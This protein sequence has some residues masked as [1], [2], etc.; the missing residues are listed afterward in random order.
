MNTRILVTGG[1]GFIGSHLVER[2]L[3]EG[4]AVT[5]IDDCSTGSLDNLKAVISHPDL[6][7]LHAK[8]SECA[9]LDAIAANSSFIFH[10]AAAVGVELVVHSP[11]RTIQTNLHETE[12]ILQ[13]AG[14]R[15]VPVL[16]TSTSEVYGKSQKPAF[17]EEDD[18]LIGPPFLGRWSYAC[19]KLMDEFLALAYAQEKGLPVVVARI[20]NTVGP[21]QTGRYGMVLPRFIEAAK[22]GLPLKVFGDGRQTRCF[23]YV[24][25]TV[26]ALIRLQKSTETRGGVFN[27]GGTEEISIRDLAQLVVRVL[28]SKSPIEFVPYSEAYAVGFQDMQRRKPV[29]EKLFRT[30][31][32]R[33]S[34]PLDQVILKTAVESG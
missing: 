27:V 30:V 31:Q 9:D 1:A 34:T 18:L 12:V 2:L 5:V 15:S 24:A 22:A 19:S 4:N 25:D 20:F 23:C 26:E 8:V 28:G 11:I 32:F 33:P 13:A 7:I 3:R 17:S 29:V 16:L 6:R 21:R 14:A 10:L